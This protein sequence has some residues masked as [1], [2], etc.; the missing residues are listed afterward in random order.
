MKII[1]VGCGKVGETLALQLSSEGHDI[2]VIDINGERVDQLSAKGDI[3]GIVGNG[4][5]HSVQ[6]EAGINETDLLIAVTES[7]ELNLLC[8]MIAKKN[9]NCRVIAKVQNPDYRSE[10]PYLKDELGLAMVINPEYAAAKEIARVL[11]F[12]SA[13][14]IETFSKGEVELIKFR[15]EEDCNIIGMSVKE[16]AMKYGANI[17]VC[18]VER[19]DAAYIAN[20]DFVFKTRDLVSIV[21]SPKEASLFFKKINHSTHAVKSTMIIGSSEISEYLCAILN[22]SGINLKIIDNDLERC[23][24][25]SAEL[26]HVTVIHADETDHELL[27]EEGIESTDAFVTLTKNDEENVLLSLFAKNAGKAKIIA[28]INNP[29]YESIINH[30]DLDTTIYP[31]NITSDMIVRYVRAMSNTQ[32]SNVETMYNI[33]KG[34]IEASE[35][36]IGQG[37]PVI[38]V[39]LA[40]LKFKDDVLIA[41]ILR[42]GNVIIPHG[43]DIIEVGDSVIVVTKILGLSDIS[44][45]LK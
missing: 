42:G 35:F 7:D 16:M 33:I 15:L 3:M 23:E 6:D 45:I 8:C 2:T 22:R 14:K 30:L 34:K 32:G 9:A 17:L 27:V 4:A 21:G 36:A 11:R 39:P 1:I 31:K 43:Q 38:G 19:D 18:T 28:K 24:E 13:T 41:A 29:E 26:E 20:G 40:Q 44:D 37:A 10:I 5:M 12:P 25:L